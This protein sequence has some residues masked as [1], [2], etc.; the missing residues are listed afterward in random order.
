MTAGRMQLRLY[1]AGT[2]SRSQGALANL[3]ELLESMGMRGQYDLELVDVLER[4]DLAEQDLIAVTPTLVRRQPLPVRRLLG[5]LSD[6][7][8]VAFGLD[9]H[10]HTEPVT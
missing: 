8:A 2:T 7:E 3:T 1:L 6:R 4:P 9:L 5:D 10:D